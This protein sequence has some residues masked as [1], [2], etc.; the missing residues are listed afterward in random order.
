MSLT[1]LKLINFQKHRKLVL[2]LSPTI[3]TIVGASDQGKS[4][5]IRALRW[6]LTNQP[7]GDSFISHGA[8]R[9]RVDVTIDDVRVSRQRGKGLN[10]YEMRHGEL[11]KAFGSDVPAPVAQLANITDT[12]NIQQQH[13]SYF[14]LTLPPA[15]VTKEL[16]KIVALDH[17]DRVIRNIRSKQNENKADLRA[18]E[19][20]QQTA[21]EQLEELASVPDETKALEQLDTQ[22][23]KYGSQCDTIA[24]MKE[25]VSHCERLQKKLHTATQKEQLLNDFAKL[26]RTLQSEVDDN[27]T[28]ISAIT[29][30]VEHAQEQEQLLANY[31]K[32]YSELSAEHNKLQQGKCP[33][34]Q[35]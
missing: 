28:D 9:C 21:Q 14:W 3:T 22:V 19:R 34:C 20:L 17:I 8:T 30:L 4:A 13:N 24:E 27:S 32:R 1:R 23:K 5:I 31:R 18:A 16:N 15:Q 10:Q 29:D 26:L 2:D 11:Y 7:N 33:L 12:V 6:V 25:C 35:K